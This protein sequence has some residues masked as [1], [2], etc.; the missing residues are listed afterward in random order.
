MTTQ[1]TATYAMDFS[2]P[3]VLNPKTSLLTADSVTDES[4]NSLVTSS[5]VLSQNKMAVH[6]T[7]TGS[8][9]AADTTYSM[10]ATTTA[11]DGLVFARIGTLRSL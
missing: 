3:G 6:F 11:T 1:D 4:G 2:L 10:R 5:V 7:V 9:L 8:D